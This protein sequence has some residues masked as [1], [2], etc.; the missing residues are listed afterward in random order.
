MANAEEVACPLDVALLLG[1]KCW[2]ARRPEALLD[3]LPSCTQLQMVISSFPMTNI[4]LGL[5]IS[6]LKTPYDEYQV[7]SHQYVCMLG[8]FICYKTY[9]MSEISS[10]HHY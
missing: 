6:K 7:F 2:Q 5:T 10:Q 1:G 3:T 9:C 8:F 4:T